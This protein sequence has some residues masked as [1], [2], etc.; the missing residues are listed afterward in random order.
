MRILEFFLTTF[1]RIIQ[2]ILVRDAERRKKEPVFVDII[3]TVNEEKVLYL[4]RW[5]ICTTKWGN[6]YL[7][8]I[9]RSDDDPDPHDHPWNFWTL[10]LWR[11]YFD[12]QYAWD[13]LRKER[14]LSN[15]E[16][17]KPLRFY[18]RKAEHCHQVKLINSKP[19]WTLVFLGKYDI[20]REWGFV[21]EDGTWVYW[22]VYLNYWKEN[23]Y[24]RIEKQLGKNDRFSKTRRNV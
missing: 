17:T 23:P 5:F 24:D 16:K 20:D 11:G 18:F 3:K 22:R 7:H 14:Y 15:A 8:K 9:L 13:V 19:A 2:F 21:K 12:M 1:L 6:L 10:I 4:R